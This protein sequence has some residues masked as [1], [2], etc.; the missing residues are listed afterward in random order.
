MK[1]KSSRLIPRKFAGNVK[2]LMVNWWFCR[3]T[4][5]MC[6]PCLLDVWGFWV[7][8][9]YSW[10]TTR[11][12]P[13]CHRFADRTEKQMLALPLSVSSTQT[14]LSQ[15]NWRCWAGPW[16]HQQTCFE[17]K[18]ES[19]SRR[20]TKMILLWCSY[21]PTKVDREITCIQYINVRQSARLAGY[22]W[23]LSYFAAACVGSAKYFLFFWLI[24]MSP[25]KIRVAFW[26]VAT[27]PSTRPCVVGKVSQRVQ[28]WKSNVCRVG[29][30]TCAGLECAVVLF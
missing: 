17:R 12:E 5:G 22:A 18:H 21:R 23:L 14:T 11:F 19:T 26:S 6:F 4:F 8:C 2:L 10:I 9:F 16:V 24:G 1:A 28:G 27:H 3:R 7:W 15:G 13:F 25:T 20:L 29:N 30:P